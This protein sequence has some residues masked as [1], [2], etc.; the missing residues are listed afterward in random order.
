MTGFLFSVSLKLYK[1]FS[2]ENSSYLLLLLALLGSIG[3]SYFQ[4]IFKVKNRDRKTWILFVLRT[5]GILSLLVLLVNPKFEVAS[6]EIVKPQLSVLVDNSASIRYLQQDKAANN[7]VENLM[8]DASLGEKFS[9][10]L[11]TFGDDLSL[12]DSLTF[13]ASETNITKSLTSF[14]TLKNKGVGAAILVTDGNQTLG[15]DYKNY[16]SAIPVY[17]LVLGD[18]VRYP[19]VSIARVNVNRYAYV[20]N[21]FPIEVFVNSTGKEKTTQLVTVRNKGKVLQRQRVV[22][23]PNSSKRV[24]FKMA[25]SEKGT[26]FYSVQ[27]SKLSQ[28]KN[29]TNNTRRFSIETIEE[30]SKIALITSVVHPDIGAM[31]RSIESNEKRSVSVISP[32]AVTSLDPYQAILLMQ[33]T[34]AEKKVLEKIKAQNK[35]VFIITGN[36]TDY[37]FL[38]AQKL[39]FRKELLPEFE[40][41]TAYYN[42]DFLPFQQQNI[43]FDN[44]S[45]LSDVFGEISVSQ[46]HDVLLY[47]TINGYP[48]QQP[49][50]VT[51]NENQQKKVLLF[52]E[53]IWQWRALSFQNTQSFKDFDA[54]VNSLVQFVT[55]STVKNRLDVEVEP[56]HYSNQSVEMNAYFF[57][58]NYQ[59][60]NKA[61]L[62]IELTSSQGDPVMQLPFSARGNVYVAEIANLNAGTY[63]YT[64]VE[65]RTNIRKKGRIEVLQAEI[66]AQFVNANLPDLSLLAAA[67]KGAVYFPDQWESLRTNLL[68]NDQLKSVQKLVIQRTNLFDWWYY[69]LAAIVLFSAEWFYRKYHGLV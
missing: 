57:D 38:N 65:K 43:G 14:N 55:N 19:D 66:E 58:D 45:P 62:E 27:V 4:Y 68:N 1:L 11:Y 18:T 67:S 7:L 42:D 28:E 30:K 39:G 20:G 49:L 16:Q 63:Q 33:P 52:G 48:T 17:P 2:L 6:Y 56:I 46:Q 25:A 10:H 44:F 60:D 24:L 50:L 3:L 51:V 61:Q 69:L 37:D 35:N 12:S 54:F 15:F 29:T 5:F 26:N 40:K 47:Q 41:V 64:V 21:Q 59:F 31:K 9:M 8:K 13:T 32:D 36:Q 34:A 53:G 23:M 22:L